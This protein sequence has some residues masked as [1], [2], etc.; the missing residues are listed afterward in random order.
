[1]GGFGCWTKLTLREQG[2]GPRVVRTHAHADLS[3]DRVLLVLFAQ[4][5]AGM[6]EL[7]PIVL[8]QIRASSDGRKAVEQTRST[9]S[10]AVRQVGSE[11]G[12]MPAW[13]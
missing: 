1:M 5:I 11:F 9:L 8:V 13:K 12:R 3:S 10:R 7:L 4:R 2:G 6:D